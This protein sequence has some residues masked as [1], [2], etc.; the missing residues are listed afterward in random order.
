MHLF[1]CSACAPFTK[2]KKRIQ[3]FK[4]T[5]DLQ[6][7]YQNELD[8]ACFQA[9]FEDLTRTTALDRVLRDKAFNIAKNS[10]YNGYQRGLASVVCNFLIK[11]TPGGAMKNE[12]V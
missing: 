2:K 4:E 12:I 5:R 6:Y 8:Q 9:C 10:K 7:I 11:K 3:K 1:L